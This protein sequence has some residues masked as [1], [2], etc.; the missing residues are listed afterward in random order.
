MSKVNLNQVN[1]NYNLDK[2]NFGKIKKELNIIPQIIRNHNKIGLRS[3]ISASNIY[4]HKNPCITNNS[5]KE[6]LELENRNIYSINTH[7]PVSLK[8]SK[9]IQIKDND[10]I[11]VISNANNNINLNSRTFYNNSLLNEEDIFIQI[12]LE[13]KKEKDKIKKLYDKKLSELTLFYESKF[14][15]LNKLL[16]NNIS[17]FTKLSTNYISLNEHNKIINEIKKTYNDLLYNTK[18]NYEKI[19]NDLTD[20]MKQKI[21]Y[22]DLIHRLQ[23]YT[24]YEIDIDEIEKKIVQNFNEKINQ[25][26]N[27]KDYF[28]DFYLITQLDEDI[29]YHK[30]ICEINQLYHE[31][32]AETRLNQNNRFDNLIKYVNNI[33]FDNI[34]FFENNNINNINNI[35][36]KQNLKLS[37]NIIKNMG[38]TSNKENENKSFSYSEKSSSKEIDKLLNIPDSYENRLKPEIMEIKFFEN[39]NK[40]K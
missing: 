3:C 25:E 13:N 24:K 37:N 1:Y 27:N 36:K 39:H 26:I 16:Q 2:L 7:N 28:K 31:K 21:K 40:N 33:F 5:N 29:N 12:K 22:K 8:K 6:I 17:D 18:Q 11:N 4:S 23:L 19:I 32:L 34:C 15:N 35:N 14:E 9:S 20:I 10:D 30:K 38:Q